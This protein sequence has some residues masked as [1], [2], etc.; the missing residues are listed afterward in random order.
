MCPTGS[1]FRTEFDGGR[2]GDICNGCGYCVPA[3]PYGVIDRRRATPTARPSSTRAS[4]RSARCYDRLK[5]DQKPACAQ[6][7][8][9][10]SIQ[11]GDVEELRE[12]ADR[13]V[14]Q[15]HEAGIMD[16]RLYGN[17]PN[18]G[19]GGTGAF[20]LLSTSRRSTASRR[21]RS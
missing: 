15:L 4:P 11:Y 8:P 10:E 3:C 1:L 13:R 12:R 9:T 21:T 16:A 7:C 2:C 6:A 20:F 17:D 18:D 5:A 14:A 19:V